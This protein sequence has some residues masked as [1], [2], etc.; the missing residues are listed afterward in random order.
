[1]G[2]ASRE[3]VVA[4]QAVRGLVLTVDEYVG[5]EEG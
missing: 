5:K 4:K 1:M 3:N 2:L